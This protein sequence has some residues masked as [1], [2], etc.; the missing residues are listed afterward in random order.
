MQIKFY[1]YD[2]AYKTVEDKT[3]IYLY[4]K[5]ADG[6]KVCIIKQHQPFFY[7][8]GDI[9]QLI[10]PTPTKPAKIIKIEPAEK[11]LLG[12]IIA[13]NKITV[14]YPKAV[15]I[16]SK[17]LAARGI[18]CYEKDILYTHRT[19]RDLNILP[20]T[21]T[22]AEGEFIESK[23]RIPTFQATK[24]SDAGKEANKEWNIL[25][26]DIETYAKKKEI[27]PRINPVLMIAFYGI[28]NSQ[29]YKKVITW[30]KFPH[31]LD[32]LEIVSDEATLIQRCKEIILSLQPEIL[33]GYYSDGF[34]LPYLNARADKHK[35][36]FDLGL[37]Y[38]NIRIRKSGRNQDAKI[39]G[40]LHIDIFKF[41][42]YIL[43]QNLKT[44]SYSLDSVASELLGHRKKEV[45]LNHLH[46]AWDQE[47]EKLSDFCEYNLHDSHLTYQLTEKLIPDILEFS[48]II[49]VP[50]Y[51]ILRMRFSKLVENYIMRRAIEYNVLAPNKADNEEVSQRMDEH[52]QGAF[53]FQPIPGLYKDVIVFDFRSLYPTII[54]AHNLGPEALHC[55]CCREEGRVPERKTL[56]FCTKQDKFLP[57]VLQQIVLRRVDLK[58]LIKE[59]ESKNQNTKLLEARSYALKILANSFYGYLSF[60]GALWYSFESAAAT[61]AYARSYI[62]TTIKE[63]ENQG[64][65]VIYADTDSCFLLLGQK[66]L[67]QAMEFMNSINFNLPG[68]M[69]LEYEGHFPRAIFVSTKSSDKGAKKKYALI[70]ENKK[71]KITG[72]AAVRRNVSILAKEIQEQVLQLV[73]TDKKEQAISYVKQQIKTLKEGQTPLEKLIIKTQITRELS[74]YT[75]IGP[76]VLIARKLAEGGE[77]INPGTIIEYVISKGTGLIRDRAKLLHEIQE[78]DPDYY[79]NN[80]LLPA[81]TQIFEVLGVTEDELLGEGKQTGLGNFF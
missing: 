71:I 80:Q 13:L 14:N 16:I 70:D 60:F 67:D 45:D 53:V 15:P 73:L 58:R 36:P 28:I 18:Q 79:L 8:I 33:T 6:S 62:K 65:T 24:I 21:L 61:T 49:G 72:F 5:L 29:P 48:K 50:T 51:D 40:I 56:W 11:Q 57:S 25:A 7:A 19:L 77:I 44:D 22:E 81:I 37:D 2:F 59:Q 64:F 42:K 55:K 10:I 30:K 54:T 76:H 23:L 26:I 38:S 32:Y 34:D 47:N 39:Q 41:I 66:H 35:I 1:P 43:G 9:P 46:I 69:E 20:L 17:E 27:N 68:H 12:K 63:A 31:D 3:Y 75:S 4:S 74:Q 78:Y 52:I